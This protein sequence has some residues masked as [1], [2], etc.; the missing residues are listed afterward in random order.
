VAEDDD[1]PEIDLD[2]L[3]ELGDEPQ[4]DDEDPE[5]DDDGNP[6]VKGEY[7]PPTQAEFERMQRRLKK[8][9]AERKS[10]ATETARKPAEDDAPA[11]PADDTRLVRAAGIAA[12]VGAGLTKDQAK[13]AVRLMDLRGITVDEDG[14]ADLEDE[15]DELKER[16]PGLF[17]RTVAYRRPPAARRT[18]E[19][20][21]PEEDATKRTDKKILRAAGFNV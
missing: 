13:S 21:T 8:F 1:Q 19:K 7:K 10:K 14:D 5:L 20:R 4:D 11:E 16:F 3:G 12:L 15:V 17:E 18:P 6:V 9:A 2:D